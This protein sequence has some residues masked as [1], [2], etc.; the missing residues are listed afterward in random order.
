[1]GFGSQSNGDGGERTPKYTVTGVDY[2][3]DNTLMLQY[4]STPEN[5]LIVDGVDLMADHRANLGI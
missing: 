3:V 4:R 1:M 2:Y 5:I